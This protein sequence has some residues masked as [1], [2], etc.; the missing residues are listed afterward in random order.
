LLR[1][2]ITPT[3]DQ[4]S[5]RSSIILNN[6]IKYMISAINTTSYESFIKEPQVGLLFDRTM[7]SEAPFRHRPAV[8]AYNFGQFATVVDV[9]G[10]NGALMAEI[11]KAYPHQP[12]LSSICRESR[13]PRS[14][15]STVAGS[16]IVAVSSRA[17]LSRPYP[18]AAITYPLQFPCQLGR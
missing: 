18:A 9:G 13:V 11:L 10:G 16:A 7:A 15:Q 4:R 6:I 2:T 14:R 17:M 5:D 12:V 8:E 1:Q 3:L